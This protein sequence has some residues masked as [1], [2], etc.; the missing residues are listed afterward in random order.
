VSIILAY[1][2]KLKEYTVK[3]NLSTPIPSVPWTQPLLPVSYI[4]SQKI[5]NTY[6]IIDTYGYQFYALG[7]TLST[8]L[9]ITSLIETPKQA[10]LLA[11]RWPCLSLLKAQ[12]FPP[13]KGL[14]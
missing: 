4:F 7:T 3:I 1:S 8:L 5:V 2:T 12:P 14:L 11:S 6:L 9:S 13:Y 10:P